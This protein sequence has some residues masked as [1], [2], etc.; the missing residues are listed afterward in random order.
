MMQTKQGWIVKKESETNSGYGC[1]PHERSIEALIKNG[2]VVV[3]KPEGPTSHEVAAWVKN[4]LNV[5]R[6]GHSGTLDPNVTGVLPTTLENA[7]KIVPALMSKEKEYVCLMWLHKKVK[8]EEVIKAAEELKGVTSQIPPLKSAVKRELRERMIYELKILEIEG[9]DVLFKTK[10]EA[11]TYIRVLCADFGR[12]LGIKA[13]MK[14]LR[15]IKAG[16]FDENDAVK[17]HDVKDAYTYWVENEDEGIREIVK[18]IEFGAQHLGKI[19][20]KD[21]AIA[22]IAHGAPLH[23]GGI[24]KFTENIKRGEVIAIMSLKGE[25]VALG[26]SLMNAGEIKNKRVGTVCRTTRVIID[27]KTYPRCW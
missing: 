20:I 13:Q 4:I 26:Q 12:K 23:I 19:M 9:Q 18:P 27:E 1:Y 15:R 16:P 6:V 17:L 8:K 24:S 7:T 5:K 3:D 10:V 11:G 14:Q 21:S 22:A 25:L 2:I